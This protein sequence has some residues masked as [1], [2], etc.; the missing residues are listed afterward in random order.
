MLKKAHCIINGLYNDSF[1]LL[2]QKNLTN[3]LTLHVNLIYIY[4]G[5]EAGLKQK[6]KVICGS[7]YYFHNL[8]IQLKYSSVN[9]SN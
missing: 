5:N 3:L 2:N 4:G 1:Y 6:F 7:F 8:I 9:Y